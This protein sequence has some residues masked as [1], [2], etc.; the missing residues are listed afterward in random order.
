VVNFYHVA[1]GA[2]WQQGV[3]KLPRPSQG[4]NGGKRQVDTLCPQEDPPTNTET[5]DQQ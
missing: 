3:E 1:A 5:N 2:S 4:N